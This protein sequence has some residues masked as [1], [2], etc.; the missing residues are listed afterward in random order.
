MEIFENPI[1]QQLTEPEIRDMLTLARTHRRTYTRH[2][3]I[4]HTGDL[5]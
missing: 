3:V 5:I 4:F 1:F 2:S